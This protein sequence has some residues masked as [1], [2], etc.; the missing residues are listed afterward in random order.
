MLLGQAARQTHLAHV[1]TAA[2]P[3]GV[4]GEL[5]AQEIVDKGALV[6]QPPPPP[7]ERWGREGVGAMA[8]PT[9][10]RPAALS[11]SPCSF[12]HIQY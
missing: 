4:L 12:G 7:C 8:V 5:S 3:V 11:A 6:H 2:V 1:D 10:R 9:I